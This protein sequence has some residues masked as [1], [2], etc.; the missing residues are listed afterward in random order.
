[1]KLRKVYRGV[2]TN[3]YTDK[4]YQVNVPN[5]NICLSFSNFPDEIIKKYLEEEFRQDLIENNPIFMTCIFYLSNSTDKTDIQFMVTGKKK[6]L[7]TQ[8]QGLLREIEEEIGSTVRNRNVLNV[9]ENWQIFQKGKDRVAGFVLLNLEEF[10]NIHSVIEA[11]E[12]DRIMAIGLIS[13]QDLFLIVS[14][15][16]IRYGDPRDPDCG[17]RFTRTIRTFI[18]EGYYMPPKN[19]SWRRRGNSP[20]RKKSPMRKSPRRKSPRG[21]K[22]QMRRKSPRRRV[23]RS[24]K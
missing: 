8:E 4:V 12:K 19:N 10:M 21:K 24:K 9:S 22:S 1:M 6:Y 15:G 2:L 20:I 3:E 14:N 17:N 23:I 7:E 5:E 16:S 11:N 13:L 18:N